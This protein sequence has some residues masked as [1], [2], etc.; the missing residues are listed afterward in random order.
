MTGTLF[1]NIRTRV[2][3]LAERCHARG[4]WTWV[5]EP[6]VPHAAAGGLETK[7]I[8]QVME[9]ADG[10]LL[11]AARHVHSGEVKLTA[12]AMEKADSTALRAAFDL[13]P[14]S[15]DPEPLC[16]ALWQAVAIGLDV[17]P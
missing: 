6:L 5:S 11:S 1:G 4:V 13:R 15:A 7:P 17:H 10:V 12:L 8:P 3:E 14:G 2:L 9:L 16:L